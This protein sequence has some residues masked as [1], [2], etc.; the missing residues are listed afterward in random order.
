MLPDQIFQKLTAAFGSDVV[1]LNQNVLSPFIMVKREKAHAILQL[2]RDDKDLAFDYLQLVTAIDYPTHF[3]V[4]YHLTSLQ[5]LHNIAIKADLPREAPSIDSVAD[6][7]PAAD[8]HEREQ[9]DLMGIDFTG[10]PDLHR[11]LLPEDWEGYPLRKDYVQPEEYHGISNTRTVGKTTYPAPDETAK[12]IPPYKAPEPPK[13]LAP[14]PAPPPADKP[15]TP[16]S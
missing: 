13:P 5:H 1:E 4:A 10:H 12:A 3:T 14:S 2:L 8:W 6:L 15:E 11:I 9:Y 16:K 7:W